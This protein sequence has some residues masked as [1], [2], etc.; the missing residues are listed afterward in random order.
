VNHETFR[1]YCLGLEH[2]TEG[3]PFGPE[4]LVFKVKGKMFATLAL[5]ES[6]GRVNLKCNPDRALQLR[7]QFS[8]ILPGYHMNKTHWNTL[9]MDGEIPE[10]LFEELI[11]HSYQLIWESLPK[12]LREGHN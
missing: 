3:T 4:V 5:E 6:P 8:S 12:K 10:D 7:E 2:T 1:E 9:V 11:K